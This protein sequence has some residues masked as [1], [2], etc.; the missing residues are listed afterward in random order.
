MDHDPLYLQTVAKRKAAEFHPRL[1][2]IY[3][4]SRLTAIRPLMQNPYNLAQKNDSP[5]AGGEA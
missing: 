1:V 2:L 4:G 3:H 5:S